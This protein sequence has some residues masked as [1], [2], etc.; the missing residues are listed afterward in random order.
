MVD[1]TEKIQAQ[2]DQ[3]V[4]LD[5]GLTRAEQVQ[6]WHDTAYLLDRLRAAEA[7]CE[8]VERD[9]LYGHNT[10][11]AMKVWFA[12]ARPTEATTASEGDEQ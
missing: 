8:A 1:R 6:A 5:G 9:E 4:P 3:G 2:L 7:V 11:T 10:W 12:L